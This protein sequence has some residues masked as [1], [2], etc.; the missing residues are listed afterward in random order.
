MCVKGLGYDIELLAW[1][2]PPYG[3]II[4]YV[5]S[6]LKQSILVDIYDQFQPC[7]VNNL[8]ICGQKHIQSETKNF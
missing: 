2:L 8:F 1:Y 5:C 6:H 3:Q 7:L 4:T